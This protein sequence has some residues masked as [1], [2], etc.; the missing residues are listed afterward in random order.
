MSNADDAARAAAI[1]KSETQIR[2]YLTDAEARERLRRPQWGFMALL[3]PF[4]DDA[5]FTFADLGAGPGGAARAILDHYPNATAVLADFSPLMK[6]EAAAAM[7]PYAGRFEYVEFD[8]A[9]GG[10]WPTSIPHQLDAVVTSQCVHHL[11]DERKQ[12]LFAEIWQRLAPGGWYLNFDPISSSDRLVDEEW[13]RVGDRIDPAQKEKRLHRTAEQHQRHEEHVRFMMPLEPQVD[14]VRAAGFE[15]VDV[16][17]KQLDY[18]IY[19]G[20]RPLA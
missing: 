10:E 13:L 18:V 4:E 5:S 16:Y 17:W 11:P 7:R 20:R 2:D 19:G 14:F 1:W 8:M 9:T 6:E 3:L 12:G 15:A